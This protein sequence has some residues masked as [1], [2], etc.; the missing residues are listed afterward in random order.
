VSEHDETLRFSLEARLQHGL[1]AVSLAVL[2]LTGLPIKF[3]TLPWAHVVT[4]FFGGFP[5]LL[6]AHFAAAALLAGVAVFYLVTL[7]RALVRGRLDFSIVPRPSDFVD[8]GRHL[9]YLIGLRPERP[10]FG[11]FTWW[12]KFEFWAVVWGT[13]LMGLS[14][15]ILAF[16]ER[17]SSFLPRWVVG[18]ARVAHSN[19]ALLAFLAVVIGHVFAVHLSPHVFPG[20]TVWWNGRISLAQLH[21]D[22]AALYDL[23]A[24]ARTP[25]AAPPP[26]ASRASASPVAVKA[27]PRVADRTLIAVELV[28]FLGLVAAVWVGLVPYLLK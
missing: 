18:V 16:P 13:T 20:S 14:G 7:I 6:S 9:A 2:L 27:G 11:K 24:A 21:E 1:L 28:V 5:A 17:A 10:R 4:A 19:E 12:E 8:F 3:A 23:L 25:A 26:A 22:H 15:L